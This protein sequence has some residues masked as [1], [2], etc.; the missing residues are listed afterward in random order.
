MSELEDSVKEG[1][2][3]GGMTGLAITDQSGGG[4][5]LSENDPVE[6]GGISFHM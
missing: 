5:H 2:V 1:S 3:V 6:C 4:A